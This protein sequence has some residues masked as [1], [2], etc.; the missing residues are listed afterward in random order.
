MG[1]WFSSAGGSVNLDMRTV[2]SLF[3][4]LC[5]MP[6]AVGCGVQ[7]WWTGATQG[8]LLQGLD[9]VLTPGQPVKLRMSLRG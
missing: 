9:V 5:L 8:T 1:G 3:L 2:T 6:L 7:N 4:S